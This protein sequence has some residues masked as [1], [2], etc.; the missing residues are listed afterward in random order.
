VRARDYVRTPDGRKLPIQQLESHELPKWLRDECI[1]R[2]GFTDAMMLL[3][4]RLDATIASCE[5][6]RA[7]LDDELYDYLEAKLKES[8]RER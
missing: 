4:S 8:K 2:D 6:Q 3:R 5:A 7:A 1:P